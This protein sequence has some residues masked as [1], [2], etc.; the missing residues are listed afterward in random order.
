MPVDHITEF[1]LSASIGNQAIIIF[2]FWFLSGP[3][4]SL[5]IAPLQITLVVRFEAFIVSDLSRSNWGG[6]KVRFG[7][8]ADIR[9][10]DQ[11]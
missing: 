2:A 3:S 7:S 1:F 6:H 5:R 10:S 8:E 9:L 11:L 4:T